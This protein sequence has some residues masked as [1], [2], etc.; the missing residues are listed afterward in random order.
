[1]RWLLCVCPPA[2]A[3]DCAE[4]RA[5]GP[6][7]P[8]CICICRWPAR[9]PCR[10]AAAHAGQQSSTIC[11]VP[12]MTWL[13]ELPMH[14]Q[15]MVLRAAAR[16][17]ASATQYRFAALLLHRGVHCVALVRHGSH[18]YLSDDD[19][20]SCAGASYKVACEAVA[21]TGRWTPC[22]ALYAA[23]PRGG[24]TCAGAGGPWDPLGL[25]HGGAGALAC[26][27]WQQPRR[28]RKGR[29]KL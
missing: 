23:Q 22:L 29:C 1:M 3:A 12:M 20:V 5:A 6:P 7:P 14:M 21:A 9:T 17:S 27:G 4:G 16:G 25:S 28:A 15:A 18:Y 8:E 13:M 24:A 11:A 26:D 2:T 19:R 10:R